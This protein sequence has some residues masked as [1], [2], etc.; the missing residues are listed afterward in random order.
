LGYGDVDQDFKNLTITNQLSVTTE[1]NLQNAAESQGQGSF[2]DLYGDA[3][4]IALGLSW[5]GLTPVE[6]LAYSVGAY[7]YRYDFD[8]DDGN[9]TPDYSETQIRF[10]LGIAYAFDFGD[11]SR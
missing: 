1:F 10:D 8:S 5:T 11:F 3:V 6:G 9:D 4:A 7:G 2:S